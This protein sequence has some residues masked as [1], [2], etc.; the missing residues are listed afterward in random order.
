MTSQ[1]HEPVGS[2]DIP[3]TNEPHGVG[4]PDPIDHGGSAHDDEELGPIDVPAWA[5]GALGIAVG[6][7]TAACFALSTGA[8]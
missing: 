7:V 1:P 4:E 8:I 6:I 3:P 2:G 5:A